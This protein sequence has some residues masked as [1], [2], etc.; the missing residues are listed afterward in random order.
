MA[1]PP[2][3]ERRAEALRQEIRRHDYLYYV[4]DQPEV[5]DHAYDALVREL[6]HLEETWPE[7]ITPDSPTQRVGGMVA[8]GFSPVTHSVPLLSLDNAFS[9]ADLLDFDR[10]VQ[11]GL[12]AAGM[13]PNG[14][15]IYVAEHKIDGLTVA[16]RYEHGVLVRAA[17]RGDG[18]TGEDVTANV[19]TIRSVPLRL[20]LDPPPAVLEVRGEV[21]MPKENFERLNQAREEAGEPLFANPRNAAAGSVRQLDPRITA[22]RALDTFIYDLLV[23]DWGGVPGESPASHH[24]ALALMQKA[25]FK[26]NQYNRVCRGIREAWQYCQ[27]WTQSRHQLGY[28]IDGVVIKLDDLKA[29]P[30]LGTTAHG[31]R[32]ATA[33]KF[34]AEEAA[35]RVREIIVGV[36]RT[37]V[38]TPVAVFDPV[39]L[40][41]TTVSRA[42]LHNEDYVAEKDIRVGDWV[43]VHKA[44]DIIPEVVRVLADRRTGDEVPFHMPDR[45]PACGS[46]VMRLPGEA[47][48]RCTAGMACPAQLREGLIHFGT[49]EAM[50]I[51]GLGPAV[52]DALLGSGLVRTAA[53]L[54]RLDPGR[55]AALERM[56]PKSAENLLNAIAA[57]RTRPLARL[58]VALGI[59]HV[60]KRVAQDLANHF[61]TMGALAAAAPDALMAVPGVGPEIAQAV[62]NFFRQ[63]GVHTLLQDLAAA[64][65]EAARLGDGERASE[66][67]PVS[68]PLAGMTIVIT[69]TLQSMTRTEAEAA[70]AAAGGRASGSV[71]KK[72]AAVVVGENP[73]SKYDR[74]RALGVPIWTEKEFLARLGRP[75]QASGEQ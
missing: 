32:W 14:G 27:E 8:E 4:L 21:F 74:A 24:E 70:V 15:V 50:D 63:E 64:G 28:Q 46:Q 42:S 26:V 29:R 11:A 72:T 7:L 22:S 75:V 6:R 52:V 45:C 43:V 68:G 58:L 60:G 71:S 61:G 34:P 31:P 62:S 19:R 66:A 10:R 44:G 36:G 49:R 33:Y 51:N 30:V 40:A 38:L 69:G 9:E 47:A 35:T 59:P 25:G 67:A 65:V 13:L 1:I 18:I 37:G 23:L 73:G 5:P 41:G 53:D 20:Q 3:V 17:T 39:H 2:E 48:T 56:G 55:V 12:A 57:S 16:L 54:Y